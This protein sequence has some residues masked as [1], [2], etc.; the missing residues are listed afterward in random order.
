MSVVK[1]ISATRPVNPP[2][3][4]IV[5][6]EAQVWEGLEIKLRH[7][8]TFV[9]LITFSEL[10]EDHGDK[11]V[12]NIR[13][14]GNPTLISEPC[15]FYANTMARGTYPNGEFIEDVISYG[16][17]DELYFSITCINILVGGLGEP[18]GGEPPS[19]KVVAARLGAEIEKALQR[20]RELVE[21][22]TIPK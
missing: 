7:P 22:G 20:I 21:D 9:D 16:P 3:C 1:S 10:A 14:K 18:E 19:A 6:T 5:L 8:T 15:W 2:G 17:N 11:I 13:L 12:R 4:S